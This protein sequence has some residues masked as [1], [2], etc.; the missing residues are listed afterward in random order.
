VTAR[1]R[2]LLV[3]LA[4]L[5]PR[6]GAQAVRPPGTNLKV[7]L[8]TMGPGEHIDAR[9]GH[10]AIWIH[11]SVSKQD[12]VYNYGTFEFGRDARD[13][14]A[15]VGRFAMGQPRYWLGVLDM[16]QTIATYTYFQRNL[17]EQELDLLP[18]QRAELAERL[19]VNARAENREYIYDY[20]RDNCSTRVRDILDAVLGGALKRAT[21]GKPAEG[22][23]RFHTLRSITNDK[24]LFFLIDAGLG[25]P[26]D[27]RID[28]WDEM[29]LPEKVQERVREIRIPGADGRDVPLV[30]AEGRILEFNIFHVDPAPPRWDA[31]W[32]GLGALLALVI[33]TGRLSGGAGIAGRAAASIWASAVGIGGLA[34]LFLWFISHHVATEWNLN[35]FY[36]TPL[37]LLLPFGAWGGMQQRPRKLVAWGAL[38]VTASVLLGVVMTV[39][40]TQA[41]QVIA[42]LTALPTLAVST[43]IVWRFI[44]RR[45]EAPWSPR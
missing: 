27:G 41:D 21:V 7:F 10:N 18:A 39:I 16:Q 28:Q 5:A 20:Y 36:L 35:L 19:A 45:D 12:L 9:F 37:A 6:L 29:F 32:L 34:L 1:G 24:P 33:A 42:E 13:L 8:L 38:L 40:G 2:L 3:I 25:T 11:D 15:F 26:V 30:K 43:G 22:T 4:L 14:A 23:L 31:L 17:D 44:R